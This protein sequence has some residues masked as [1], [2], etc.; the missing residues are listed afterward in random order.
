MVFAISV[1]FGNCNY[2]HT[3]VGEQEITVGEVSDFGIAI[4]DFGR[5]VSIRWDGTKFL[6]KDILGKKTTSYGIQINQVFVLDSIQKIALLITAYSKDCKRI[7]LPDNFEIIIGRSS[8]GGSNRIDIDYPFV[9]REQCKIVRLYGNAYLEDCNSKNG[10]Y[11][12]GQAIEKASL[13]EGDIISILPITIKLY[14]DC[15]EIANATGRVS[16]AEILESDIRKEAPLHPIKDEKIWYRRSPRLGTH[17]EEKSIQLEHPPQIGGKPQINWFGVLISPIVTIGL[18]TALVYF[19]GMSPI[20]LIL[21]GVTTLLS[22]IAAV[23]SFRKQKRSGEDRNAHIYSTYRNYLKNISDQITDAHS[24]ESIELFSEHPAP[25]DCV[26]MAKDGDKL[27][28]SRRPA[29]RD[30]LSVR[31]GVGTTKASFSAKYEMPQVIVDENPLDNEAKELADRSVSIENIPVCCDLKKEHHV[32]LV[33][34]QQDTYSLAKKMIVELSALHS[35][36]ELKIIIISAP[37]EIDQW[38]WTRWLPHCADNERITRYIISDAATSE[39]LL[40]SLNHSISSRMTEKDASAQPHYAFFISSMRVL[41]NHPLKR[42]ILSH[43]TIGCSVFCFAENIIYAPGE[44]TCVIQVEPEEGCL[45]H[46]A[47]MQTQIRFTLD[48][49]SQTDAEHFARA[50]APV[51]IELEG[52]TA[53]IPSKIS[54]LEGY[55]VQRPEQLQILQRWEKAKAYEKLSVPMAILPGGGSFTFD[56]HQK[57]QGVHGIVAG[58]TGS[59]KTELVQSWLLAMAVHF[60]PQDVAFLLIDFKGT[61]LIAPFKGLPHI[62]GTISNLD[63]HADIER[64][65]ISIKS[66]MKRRMEIIDRYTAG[67]SYA[68]TAN[69]VN[70]LYHNG[71]IKENLP[72][73]LIVIDEFAEFKKE[74]P[75]FGN[76]IVSLTNV[77]RSLGMYTILMAQSP[78]GIIPAKAEDNIAFRWCLRVTDTAASR[79]M[80]GTSDAINISNPGRAYVKVENANTHSYDLIQSFWSGAPYNP[81]DTQSD[82]EEYVPISK[83]HLSG[84]KI[85]CEP[86]PEKTGNIATI[87]EIGA[88]VSYIADCCKEN[89]IAPAHQVW[90]PYLPKRIPVQSLLTNSY[91]RGAWPVT[92]CT[93]PILGLMDDPQN[94]RQFPLAL[95]LEDAGNTVIYG[96]P[97]TGKTT[98]LQTLIVSLAL[99][100]K[101]DQV[102]LYVMDL[103]GSNHYTALQ[104]LPHIGGIATLD[105]PERLHKLALLLNDLFQERKRVFSQIG[106]GNIAAYRAITK[107]ELPDVVLFVDRFVKDMEGLVDFFLELASGGANYG[108][109]LIATAAAENHIPFKLQPFIKTKFCFAMP[110]KSDYNMLVGRP[111]ALLSS[112]TGRAFAKG[113]PPMEFQAALPAPGNNDMDMVANMRQLANEMAD[114]WHG[115]VPASIPEL[116]ETVWYGTV[117]SENIVLGLSCEKVLPVCY[118]Y[119]KQHYLMISGMEKSGKTN[120]LWVI[121]QQMKEKEDALLYLFDINGSSKKY[122]DRVDAYLS[123]EAQIDAFVESIRPELNRRLDEKNAD[124]TCVFRPLVIAV[125]DYSQ[126]FE[127]VNN[128]TM[129]RLSAILHLGANL[130]LY[131]LIA[132]DAY[133][134]S[135]LVNRGE[136]VALTIAKGKRGVMLGGCMNDHA[137][138]QVKATY[139]QKETTVKDTDGVFIENQQPIAFRVMRRRRENK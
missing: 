88:V 58:M 136:P 92:S 85:S 29:D 95:K 82:A 79:Y 32:V 109:Y 2:T 46:T 74:Y 43:E 64:N 11:L 117:P 127:Q 115:M 3:F 139:A 50:L 19:M 4:P 59:G 122:T 121:M 52:N 107:Q 28:W 44:C 110:D 41:R 113:E 70:R 26:A 112:V 56:I 66:E 116:P 135:T 16:Y 106:V 90:C 100:R 129:A 108:V 14:S 119:K 102:S 17:I 125:D 6:V 87:T 78:S 93:A 128:D 55:K 9:S 71:E 36:D 67:T 98:L 104:Q 101:P 35:Y 130:E 111:R 49:L 132:G 30:Y 86:K 89:H 68:P 54:F 118:D 13:R 48:V 94:Q 72:I 18:M 40:D 103:S 12:N 123:D 15:L 34:S 83:V 25:Q 138:I 91:T 7:P 10:T 20:M 97:A 31:L 77:G 120:L 37:D 84:K 73:L 33:G 76:E 51:H 69:S 114:V 60:S 61:G 65:L 133:G 75:E 39:Q 23:F 1:L 8:I 42:T 99:T 21:T 45:Y 124:D 126:F 38:A 137:A 63:T 81:D 62:A 131:L 105:Q 47:D 24:R 53:T 80:L 134:L 22:M 96:M 57:S 27:L 5:N